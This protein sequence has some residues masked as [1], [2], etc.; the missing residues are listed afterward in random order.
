MAAADWS[1]TARGCALFSLIKGSDSWTLHFEVG[2][3]RRLGMI[4]AGLAGV[5]VAGQQASEGRSSAALI[6]GSAA[7]GGLLAYWSL[8]DA[9]TT[10]IFDLKRRQIEISS[11]RP[12]FGKPRVYAFAEVM[13]LNA[14]SRSGESVDSWEAVVELRNGSRVKLGR[15]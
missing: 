11:A 9:Q 6:V 3:L 7:A 12:W 13:A 4:G 8:A 2:P 5:A 10:A 14:V 1:R 15:E